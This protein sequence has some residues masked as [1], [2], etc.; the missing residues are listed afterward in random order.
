[1]HT[2]SI[3]CEQRLNSLCLYACLLLAS[4][5]LFSFSYRCLF[6]TA[7]LCTYSVAVV[8][9]TTAAAAAAAVAVTA[10]L[11]SYDDDDSIRRLFSI[12]CMHVYDSERT[13][14]HHE[15]FVEYEIGLVNW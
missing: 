14:S 11:L 8:V 7:I 12:V 5:Y 6:F 2:P 15:A 10:L 1:M 13:Q 9:V 3:D 4:I